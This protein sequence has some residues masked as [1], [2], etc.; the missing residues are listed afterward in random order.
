MAIDVL[1]A[2]VLVPIVIALLTSS[3]LWVFFD[4]KT[5]RHSYQTDLLKGLAHDRIVYLCLKYIKR[6]Y[7]TNEEYENLVKFLY[8]PY[9]NLGGN[10][11]AFRLME[12]VNKIPIKHSH[13]PDLENSEKE[14]N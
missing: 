13:F 1:L 9:Q 7:I 10:G 5:Q 6:G 2:Q 8:K 3:S 11:T 14:N 4:K 12:E